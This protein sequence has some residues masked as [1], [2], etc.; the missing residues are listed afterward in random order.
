[1][2]HAVQL[3]EKQTNCKGETNSSVKIQETGGND[4]NND[5]KS[6]KCD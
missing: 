6:E 4:D 1:M 2:L 5:W 3:R